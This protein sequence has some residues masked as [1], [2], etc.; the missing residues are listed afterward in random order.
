MS[1]KSYEDLA[2]DG[3]HK[4]VSSGT[5]A[6]LAAAFAVG[7][8]AS[9]ALADNITFAVIGPHE[10][11]LPVD[12]KPFNVFVQYGENNTGNRAFDKYGNSVP[13]SGQNQ[14]VG[15]SKYVYFWCFPNIT[16]IGFAYEVITPEVGVT[17]P[18]TGSGVRGVGD[19]LT[20][21]AMWFKPTPNSTLGVQN[22]VQ[23]PVGMKDVT[24][25]YWANYASIFFDAQWPIASLTGNLGVVTRS[26]QYL[27]NGSPE[28]VP[29]TTYHFNVRLGWVNATIFEPF[30]AL[31]WQTQSSAYQVENGLILA[32]HSQET[33]LGAGVMFKFSPTMSLTVRYSHSVEGKAVTMTNAGYFKL[34]YV[35]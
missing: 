1:E 8:G 6:L 21:P 15:L 34:A 24:N 12:F 2:D 35:W 20:G 10:Y 32:P 16:D 28:A 3:A 30:L 29:G 5:S 19:T 7:L 26:N 27:P 9:P 25:G 4:K 18:G 33:A 11:D 13:G 23:V 14:F 22:F 31:D 17:G